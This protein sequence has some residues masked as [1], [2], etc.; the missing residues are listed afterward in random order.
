MTSTALLGGFSTATEEMIAARALLDRIDRRFLT[1][2]GALARVLES[3]H[4]R[5]TRIATRTEGGARYRTVYFD[6]HTRAFFEDHRRGR[7]PRYK[8]RLREDLDRAL[9][10][11]EVKRKG[12]D[13]RTS[14]ARM[15]WTEPGDRLG[16][17]AAMFVDRHCPAPASVL[18]PAI[19]VTY[20][21]ITLLGDDLDERVTI[22]R[23]ISIGTSGRHEALPGLVVVEVKQRHFDNAS[24]AI[25]A[26][27]VQGVREGGLSKYILGT[28]RL[29]PVRAG[30]FRP[31]LRTV[32]RLLS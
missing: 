16:P 25:R 9:R 22:D 8:V 24:P 19:E 14:K 11:V 17:D 4:T 10:Y 7:L 3:L 5:Y 31:D 28:A 21:R 15:P 27:R 23:A 30:L 6:T 29:L 32:E 20:Q 26:L 12:P 1:T 2:D 13:T 18:A